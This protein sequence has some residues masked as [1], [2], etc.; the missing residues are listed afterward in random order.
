MKTVTP[1]ADAPKPAKTVAAVALPAAASAIALP[2]LG[3]EMLKRQASA[4]RQLGQ[5]Q[6]LALDH[7]VSEFKA[8]MGEIEELARAASLSEA[9]QIQAR[10][11]RRGQEAWVAHWGRLVRLSGASQG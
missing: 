2:A 1:K 10:A 9:L 3:E 7:A 5:V 11:F 4:A 6:A 8:G